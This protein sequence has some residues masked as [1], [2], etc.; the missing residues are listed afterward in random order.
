MRLATSV[1][2]M[3][4][5]RDV[6]HFT[7]LTTRMRWKCRLS[8]VDE[9]VAQAFTRIQWS[10]LR[11]SSFFSPPFGCACPPLET[12][13]S[14]LSHES[15]RCGG[16]SFIFVTFFVSIEWILRLSDAQ[17]KPIANY[18]NP[19]HVKAHIVTTRIMTGLSLGLTLPARPFSFFLSPFAPSRESFRATRKAT[20]AFHEIP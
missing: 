6:Y 9:L 11:S 10:Y 13:F 16:A 12:L 15:D 14:A 2:F 5:S 8:D 19:L 18:S 17:F 4:A 20:P 7:A 3:L 1:M